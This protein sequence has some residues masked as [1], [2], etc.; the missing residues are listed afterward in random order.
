MIRARAGILYALTEAMDDGHC[1]LPED[2]LL[3]AA[4]KLLEVPE[5]ILVPALAAGDR[6]RQ[7]DHRHASAI[8][9]VSFWRGCIAPSG[10]LRRGSQS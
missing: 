7:R 5:D 8:G 6:G 10:R 4:A 3:P 9:P 2:E 1:G